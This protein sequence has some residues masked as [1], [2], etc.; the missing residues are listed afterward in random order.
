MNSRIAPTSV[1]A[2][3]EVEVVAGGGEEE[4]KARDE[5]IS[6]FEKCLSISDE[7][8]EDDAQKR[9]AEV[10]AKLDCLPQPGRE[11]MLSQTWAESSLAPTPAS[12]AAQP[13]DDDITIGGVQGGQSNWIGYFKL[14]FAAAG[15]YS[16]L[17]LYLF[18]QKALE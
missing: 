5:V 16:L 15:V 10:S 14:G 8:G 3:E 1:A 11:A 6:M 12:K 2:G 18:V 13:M 7:V 4:T 9:Q 17:Y